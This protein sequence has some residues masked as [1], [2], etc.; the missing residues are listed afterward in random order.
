MEPYRRRSSLTDFSSMDDSPAKNDEDKRNELLQK[1]RRSK[2]DARSFCPLFFLFFLSFFFARHPST[3]PGAPRSHQISVVPGRATSLFLRTFAIVGDSFRQVETLL[4]HP[5]AASL[6]SSFFSVFFFRLSA[7]FCL[8]SASQT[9]LPREPPNLSRI[10]D[11]TMHAARTKR[12]CRSLGRGRLNNRR[13]FEKS[14]QPR[15]DCSR[16]C[17][18]PVLLPLPR[19]LSLLLFFFASSL[20]RGIARKLLDGSQVV[21]VSAAIDEEIKIRPLRLVC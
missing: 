4:H 14:R 19:F 20:G 13:L 6:S 17:A 11:A 16:T 2:K 1:E 9:S 8:P 3:F 21:W 10:S 15:P 7:D 12:P 5:L 18:H